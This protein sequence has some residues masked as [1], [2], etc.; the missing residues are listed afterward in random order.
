MYILYK[1]NSVFAKINIGYY[2]P[3]ETA[4]LFWAF[5]EQAFKLNV[6]LKSSLTQLQEV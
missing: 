6:D 1:Y 4:L 2:S 3:V 5:T